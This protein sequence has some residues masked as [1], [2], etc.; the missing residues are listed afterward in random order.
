MGGT[1]ENFEEVPSKG[2]Y[3]AWDGLIHGNSA[4]NGHCGMPCALPKA[5][6]LL[7]GLAASSSRSV[8]LPAELD[9]DG[10]FWTAE[11]LFD[12]GKFEESASKLNVTAPQ[13]RE[14]NLLYSDRLGIEHMY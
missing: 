11:T 12:I 10:W 13:L 3:I 9:K 2:Q 8:V 14:S 4:R 7:L 1:A 5:V 6:T